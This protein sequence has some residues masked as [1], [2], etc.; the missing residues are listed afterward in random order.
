MPANIFLA[1]SYERRFV[2]VHI[3]SCRFSPVSM[4]LTGAGHQKMA[5]S[6]ETTTS[7]V[8]I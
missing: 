2:G 4:R 5:I 8:L 7:F 1:S 6:S 3:D